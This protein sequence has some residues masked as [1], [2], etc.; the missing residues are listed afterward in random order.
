MMHCNHTS[1]YDIAVAA[2][3]GGAL[4]NP[5]VAVNA[6]EHESYI[7]HLAQKERDCITYGQRKTFVLPVPCLFPFH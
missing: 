2:I 7:K 3:R 1:R 4:S 6:R 5:K